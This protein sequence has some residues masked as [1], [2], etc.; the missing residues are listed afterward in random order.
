M[1]RPRETKS[2]EF[3]SGMPAISLSGLVDKAGNQARPGKLPCHVLKIYLIYTQVRTQLTSYIVNLTHLFCFIVQ[4]SAH[5][6]SVLLSEYSS[7][8]CDVTMF[9]ATDIYSIYYLLIKTEMRCAL[10]YLNLRISCL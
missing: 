3:A 6:K 7:H 9:V 5:Y 10:I 4:I 8:D 2:S 1:A